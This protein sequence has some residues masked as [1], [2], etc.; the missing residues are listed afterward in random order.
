VKQKLHRQ[1]D[2]DE[3]M[4]S[5]PDEATVDDTETEVSALP[6]FSPNVDVG[7]SNFDSPP[8]ARHSLSPVAAGLQ[9]SPMVG[10]G[11]FDNSDEDSTNEEMKSD[12]V[13]E[14]K[15]EEE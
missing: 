3:E 5:N 9:W 7:T 2:D 4:C 13:E 6:P 14:G 1:D 12:T 15:R 10:D 11:A 8:R